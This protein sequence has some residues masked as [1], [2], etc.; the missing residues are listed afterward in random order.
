MQITFEQLSDLVKQVEVFLTEVG[1][2]DKQTQLNTLQTE[3]SEV[4]FWDRVDAQQKMQQVSV[5]Q[6]QLDQYQQLRA[7]S[8]DLQAFLELEAKDQEFFAIETEKKYWQ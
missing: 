7:L 5:L 8:G 2:A 4:G 3:S 1:E 6:N